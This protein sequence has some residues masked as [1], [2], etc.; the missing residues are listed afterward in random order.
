MVRE[1]S[2]L[3]AAYPSTLRLQK[4]SSSMDLL[5]I[6]ASFRMKEHDIIGCSCRGT[7]LQR[8]RFAST[9]FVDKSSRGFKFRYLHMLPK[10][11]LGKHSMR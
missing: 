2:E 7:D 3:L 11:R 10:I 6:S 9:T 1:H 4:G 5:V 8:S